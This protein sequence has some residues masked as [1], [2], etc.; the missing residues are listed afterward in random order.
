MHT[1]WSS[2]NNVI[3]HTQEVTQPRVKIKTARLRKGNNFLTSI[4]KDIT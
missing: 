1:D 2:V 3:K 4:S